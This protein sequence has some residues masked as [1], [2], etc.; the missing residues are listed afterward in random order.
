MATQRDSSTMDF[1]TT[2]KSPEFGN[3]AYIVQQCDTPQPVVPEFVPDLLKQIE[4]M[5]DSKLNIISDEIRIRTEK[6]ENRLVLIETSVTTVRDDIRQTR[7]K[8]TELEKG[9]DFMN[10]KFEEARKERITIQTRITDSTKRTELEFNEIDAQFDELRHEVDYMWHQNNLMH[11]EILDLKCRSMR[12]NLLFYGLSESPEENPS[13]LIEQFFENELKLDQKISLGRVHRL[14]R[15]KS[16]NKRPRPI[17]AQF[18]FPNDRDLV[19]RN[20]HRLKY[21]GYGVSEQFPPEIVER[22]KELMP[23][24]KDAK[25][26]DKK[27]VLVVDSLYIEGERV[28]PRQRSSTIEETTTSD[29]TTS[30]KT[31]EQPQKR[32]RPNNTTPPP[33]S[34][35]HQ[36]AV[37]SP[38]RGVME[39]LLRTKSTVITA[40]RQQIISRY[41]T[42][43]CVD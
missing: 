2:T 3:P 16:N 11:E 43:T 42:R 8:V 14:G 9:M 26:K 36:V 20:S 27:A 17:V 24:L 28:Y 6:I 37:N 18:V 25:Q 32:T 35:P 39:D 12:S 23:L 29:K 40:I 33:Q 13:S 38:V 4:R 34:D 10:C 30:D 5:L 22:R 7:S 31:P 15:P 19:L 1:T 21:T 41:S